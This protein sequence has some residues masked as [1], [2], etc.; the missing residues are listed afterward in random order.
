M[1]YAI[2]TGRE[3]VNLE[4]E[5]V[6]AAG[7][8]A[9]IFGANGKAIKIYHQPSQS[10]SD[11]LKYFFG[12]Q[13]RLQPTIFVPEEPVFKG[14][15]SDLLIGFRMNCLPAGAEPL[16]MLLRPEYCAQYGITP[17]MKLQVFINLLETL[18]VI[19]PA[20]FVV[21]DLNDQNERFHPRKL[22]TYWIDVDS[23]QFGGFPC[24]VGTE[25]YLSPELYNIDLSKSPK[26]K[27]EHDYFSFAVLLFRALLLAHPFG[28]GFHRQYPTLFQRAGRG[29]TI[30][31]QEVKYPKKA[32]PAEV[33]TDDLADTLQKY[34]KRQRRDPFP[35]DQLTE[36][37]D[38]LVECGSCHL[39]YPAS[40]SGCPGCSTKT[41]MAAQIAAKVAGCFCEIILNSPGKIIYFQFI[42]DTICC[43]ADENGITV[44]YQKPLKGPLIRKELFKTVVGARYQI[45][46]SALVMCRD[47]SAQEPKLELYDLNGSFPRLITETTTAK[48]GGGA[49]FSC[50]DKKL[51]RLAG[52][53]II[54]NDLFG[55]HLTNRE[56]MQIIPNQTW[57]T[58]ANTPGLN[59]EALFGC[60]RFFDELRWFLA[61]GSADGKSY[62]R[63]DVALEPPTQQESLVDL[64]V[65]FDHKSAMVFRQTKV[66]G[67][68]Y[69]RLD[70]FN[71]TNGQIIQSRRIK[72][73]DE[74][75][76]QSIHGKGFIDEAI[77]HATDDGIVL[78]NVAN[79]KLLTLTG[80]GS[81][82]SGADQLH[83]FGNGVLVMSGER[84]LLL[85][86][87]SR[88]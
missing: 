80:T 50:S 69:I 83:R 6:L 16:A 87:D 55:N 38:L 85:K 18:L 76:Y 14:P 86:P 39:W 10:R 27:P 24:M 75:N 40:R 72:K 48:F 37:R 71:L 88:Q 26:F 51:Y 52:P 19:H 60:Q 66:R 28:S 42:R 11:K 13:Y 49:V 62:L 21:G 4:K 8:E 64:S 67:V 32:N 9:V 44:F 65:K 15:A 53:T 34:L 57:F 3:L 77:L 41:I 46:N 78:E 68:N 70:Q 31:D 2:G 54:A 61:I 25:D 47:K 17:K 29:L 20:G 82:V 63:Y 43:L 1:K 22:L 36:Y 33:L 45:F 79:Q 7:G 74:K 56:I 35:L 23:W 84:L 30:L 81:Y 73:A 59:K 58:V 12:R 5:D